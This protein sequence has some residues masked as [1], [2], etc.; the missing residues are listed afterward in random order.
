MLTFEAKIQGW[1]SILTLKA[2][3]LDYGSNLNF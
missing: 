3:V 2:E 1:V